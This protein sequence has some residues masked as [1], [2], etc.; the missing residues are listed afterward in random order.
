MSTITSCGGMPRR[1]NERHSMHANAEMFVSEFPYIVDFQSVYVRWAEFT[2][3]CIQIGIKIFIG[4][5][6]IG[7]CELSVLLQVHLNN[8]III[9]NCIVNS[10]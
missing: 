2:V 8:F 3:N 5:K 7:L 1:S 9:A 10:I 4:S 6:V